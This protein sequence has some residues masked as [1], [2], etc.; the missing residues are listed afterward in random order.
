[1]TIFVGPL[2]RIVPHIYAARSKRFDA[3]DGAVGPPDAVVDD[4]VVSFADR[5][6]DII[7]SHGEPQVCVDRHA[8]GHSFVPFSVVLD[9]HD[10]INALRPP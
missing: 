2:V 7:I 6:A 9:R 3:V 4:D 1:M 8:V 5:A 10:A